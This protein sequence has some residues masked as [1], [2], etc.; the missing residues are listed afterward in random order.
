MPSNPDV[1]YVRAAG[2]NRVYAGASFCPDETRL[3]DR[4]ENMDPLD[5]FDVNDA[6]REVQMGADVEETI[7]TYDF[8]NRVRGR[9]AFDGI[10]RGCLARIEAGACVAYPKE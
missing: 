5:V 2:S 4:C 6:R 1:I 9:M 3:R 8:A 7:R 10:I